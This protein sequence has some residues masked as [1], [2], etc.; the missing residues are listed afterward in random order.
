MSNHSEHLIVVRPRNL[1]FEQ[2]E[3]FLLL[4][5]L[6]EA[7]VRSLQALSL[8]VQLVELLLLVFSLASERAFLESELVDRVVQVDE[9][10]VL[11][12]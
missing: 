11:D 2:L 10:L 6:L 1:L 7:L 8:L 9:I 4:I 12:T 3:I 5:P